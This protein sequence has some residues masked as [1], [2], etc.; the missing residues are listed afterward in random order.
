MK[1]IIATAALMAMSATAS[2]ASPVHNYCI[3][4]SAKAFSYTQAV[5]KGTDIGVVKRHAASGGATT[6]DMEVMETVINQAYTIDMSGDE[7]SRAS[8]AASF[9]L[10][11]YINCESG[12]YF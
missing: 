4:L 7:G 9:V 8:K 12:Y 5:R 2:A 11:T 1:T 3:D 6:F 10:V